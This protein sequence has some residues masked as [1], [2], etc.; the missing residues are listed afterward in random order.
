[1]SERW[2]SREWEGWVW[3]ENSNI[4][5]VLFGST[6]CTLKGAPCARLYICPPHVGL[7][8]VGCPFLPWPSPHIALYLSPEHRSGQTTLCVLKLKWYFQGR[9]WLWYLRFNFLQN[10]I[11]KSII[12]HN[13]S[14]VKVILRK[15]FKLLWARETYFAHSEEELQ[16]PI[17]D[18]NYCDWPWTSGRHKFSISRHCMDRLPHH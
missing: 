4:S 12:R 9:Y 3:G 18:I 2:R 5:W 16:H 7:Q 1:M 6:F 14:P 17:K 10:F 8:W 13:N 11:W 15:V